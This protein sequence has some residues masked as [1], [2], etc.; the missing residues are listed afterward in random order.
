MS[1]DEQ[2]SYIIE[3]RL[4]LKGSNSIEKWDEKQA[5]ID[6]L[7]VVVKTFSNLQGLSKSS[8]REKEIDIKL[9]KISQDV[10]IIKKQGL[11]KENI[12]EIKPGAYGVSINL[13]ALWKKFKK[14]L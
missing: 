9:D 6:A 3:D 2:S 10:Q 12:V 1:V 4:I 11:N 5:R 8:M 7:D 14:K 13:K